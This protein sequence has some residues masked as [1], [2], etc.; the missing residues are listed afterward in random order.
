MYYM[1]VEINARRKALISPAE[2]GLVG[3]YSIAELVFLVHGTFP[4]HKDTI[5]RT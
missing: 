2:K 3:F 5:L 4:V 1:T